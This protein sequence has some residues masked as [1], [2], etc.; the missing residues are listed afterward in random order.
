VRLRIAAIKIAFLNSESWLL[1][2]L[3]GAYQRNFS[4]GISAREE[5]H[6]GNWEFEVLF[7]GET[8]ESEDGVRK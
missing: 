4:P 5:M 2:P 1:N 3:W 8:G 6:W 7:S